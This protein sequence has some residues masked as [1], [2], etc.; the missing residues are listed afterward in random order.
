MVES[1]SINCFGA[2]GSGKLRSMVENAMVEG[3]RLEGPKEGDS[4]EKDSGVE[5]S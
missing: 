1:T 2:G 3:R 4:T 5:D